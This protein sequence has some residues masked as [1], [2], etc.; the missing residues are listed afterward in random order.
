[1]LTS[2][3]GALLPPFGSYVV[4]L[5]QLTARSTAVAN[6]RRDGLGEHTTACIA[7]DIIADESLRSEISHMLTGDTARSAD[8]FPRA[9]HRA[10]KTCRSAV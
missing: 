7:G 3:T 2:C 4:A 6:A 5:T 8:S 9:Y 1:V 10:I